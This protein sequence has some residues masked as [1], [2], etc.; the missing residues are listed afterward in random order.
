MRRDHGLDTRQQVQEGRHEAVAR[1]AVEKRGVFRGVFK[2]L[3][4]EDLLTRHQA[5]MVLGRIAGLSPKL[6]N[7]LRERLLWAMN[8]ESGTYCNGAA[9]AMAEIA[10]VQPDQL[11]E[12]VPVLLSHLDDVEEEHIAQVLWAIGRL[13]TTFPQETEA[14]RSEVTPFLGHPDP[15]V[16]AMAA[17]AII[18]MKVPKNSD[19]LKELVTDRE[20]M[21]YVECSERL[22]RSIRDLI[23]RETLTPGCNCGPEGC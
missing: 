5:A 12:F 1:E 17:R 8:D 3:Y 18:R 11:R 22:T 13:A 20:E 10:L 15:S 9:A 4:H 21:E 14:T 2:L 6:A 19:I 7:T 16:R 23:L